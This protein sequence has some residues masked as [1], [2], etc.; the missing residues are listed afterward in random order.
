[1]PVELR[2]LSPAMKNLFSLLNRRDY[3]L[4]REKQFGVEHTVVDGALD[5]TH[6]A[7]GATHT[8]WLGEGPGKGVRPARLLK[9]VLYVATDEADDGAPVWEKWQIRHLG[10]W[11]NFSWERCW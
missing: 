3:T 1:M 4:V 2:Y 6:A 7:M 11:D 10:R 5:E 9:T 8:L